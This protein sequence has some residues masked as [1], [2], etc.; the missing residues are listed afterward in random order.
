MSPDFQELAVFV[1]DQDKHKSDD[2]IGKVSFS[3]KQI[4]ELSQG[5]RVLCL[6]DI[7]L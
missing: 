2:T 7:S 4:E 5:T 3:R 1:Y 6:F